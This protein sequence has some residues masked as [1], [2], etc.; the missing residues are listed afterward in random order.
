MSGFYK[1]SQDGVQTAGTV[2]NQG[3]QRGR[4]CGSGDK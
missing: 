1:M 3:G 2:Q 4:V